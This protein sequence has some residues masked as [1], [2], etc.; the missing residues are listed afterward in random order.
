MGLSKT[1]VARMNTKAS[2]AYHDLLRL[3]QW[4]RPLNHRAPQPL[5]PPPRK[6]G[7]ALGEWQLKIQERPSA[8][9]GAGPGTGSM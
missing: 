5:R 2:R 9:M 8:A 3:D 7:G 1:V 4:Q 6:L